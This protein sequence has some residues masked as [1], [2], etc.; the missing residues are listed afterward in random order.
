MTRLKAR[1]GGPRR[2]PDVMIGVLVLALLG[3]FGALLL[4]Q[5]PRPV[6]QVPET[7]EPSTTV[8]IPAS[9]GT[10]SELPTPQTGATTAQTGMAQTTTDQTGT[11]QTTAG[12]TTTGQTTSQPTT[13]QTATAQT[14]Q[15]QTS[16][17]QSSAT[18]SQAQTGQTAQT[19]T[20]T[21]TDQTAQSS[22]TQ[23]AQTQSS[24]AQ[25]AQGQTQQGQTSGSATTSTTTSNGTAA[26]TEIPPV[27]A[28]PPVGPLTTLPLPENAQPV[29]PSVTTDTTQGQTQTQ[30][31]TPATTAA[32]RAG[33]AVA[34]SAARTPLRSDYRISLGSF[35]SERTVRTQTAGV[36]GLGYTVYPINIG[37]GY[38]AQVG[39]FADEA[40]ARQA[41]ADIQRAS[42]GALLYRPRERAAQTEAD[43][44]SIPATGSD[45]SAQTGSDTQGAATQDTATQTAPSQ[46]AS[47]PAAQAPA[48]SGPRYLQVGA[49]DREES[50]QRLVGMLRDAGFAPTVS[51]PPEGKVTVLVG[52]YSGDALLRAEGR[53]DS[54]GMDH[55]RVR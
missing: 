50:A 14:G 42:P 27:P 39:P 5:R 34:A 44:V 47:T 21:A 20:G 10:V 31:Q 18:Q 13:S 6:A 7:A 49:F 2:W 52:P 54:A 46:E 41:L 35:A 15:G 30:D 28:T 17:A 25:T 37:D 33:G 4:E 8:V 29:Q 9:P 16:A 26:A 38:V 32:P 11:G 48:P 55:F 24:Q 40:T 45:T 12:Q 22:Q 1:S 36:S 3:G 43:R 19:Q 51:A 23:P 53:L